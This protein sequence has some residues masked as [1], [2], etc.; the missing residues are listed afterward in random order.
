MIPISIVIIIE[1]LSF[2]LKKTD[3]L[4]E[5][6]IIIHVKYFHV[7]YQFQFIFEHLLIGEA[8]MVKDLSTLFPLRV[9]LIHVFLL[10]HELILISL[11]FLAFSFSFL[12]F[13]YL[14]SLEVYYIFSFLEV[15][16]I[17]FST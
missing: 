14:L 3:F 7:L 5:A 17:Y 16:I 2:Y 4:K 15:L 1:L 6:F 11:F 13:Q 9:F 8:L 12:L 10:P